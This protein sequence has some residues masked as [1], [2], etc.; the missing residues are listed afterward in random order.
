MPPRRVE[1]TDTIVGEGKKLFVK[2]CAGCHGSDGLGP[3][4]RQTIP[5]YAPSI[6]NQ[7]FLKAADD[8]FLLAT[9]A[10]G[11]PGTPMRPFAKGLSSIAELSTEEIRQIVAFIRSWQK[12]SE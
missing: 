6:N 5:S 3:A 10:M 9:I 4:L 8:G 2:N 1:S 12:G 7:E 11:R